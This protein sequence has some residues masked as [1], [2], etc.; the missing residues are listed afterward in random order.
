[1]SNFAIVIPFRPKSESVYWEKESELLSQTIKSALLQ[2]YLQI[3]VFV[4]YTDKPME[5]IIDNRL[6]YIH[7]PFGY[8]SFNEIPVHAAL[9]EKFKTEKMVVRRWDKARKLT[10]GCKV[11]KEQGFDYIMA[12]DADDLISKNLF[13]ELAAVSENGKVPGWYM[14]QGY[15]YKPGTRFFMLVP[16]L[17]RFLNGSTHVLRSDLVTIPEFTSTNWLDYSL[18]TDHGWVKAR[19]KEYNNV[20]LLPINKPVLVYVVH[21]SNI[22]KVYQKE[23]GKTLKNFIKL[24]LRGRILTKAKREEFNIQ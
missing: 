4:V 12:L 5:L 24:L 3:K 8:Q 7:F 1:M 20:D 16:K 10:W 2:T 13:A 22:S 21:G 6:E 23:F 9:L 18:F 17:M 19:L 15:L 11:A 14:H